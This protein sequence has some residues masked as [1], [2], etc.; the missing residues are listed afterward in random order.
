MGGEAG[1]G[2]VLTG[3]PPPGAVFLAVHGLRGPADQA[4]VEAAIRRRDPAARVWTH[5]PR[6]MVA[7][8]S[9]VAAEELRLAVQD[10]GFLARQ[11]AAEAAL[12]DPRSAGAAIARAIG[13]GFAGFVLGGLGGGVAGLLNLALNPVCHSGGD[14]GGCAMGIPA[15]TIGAALLGGPIGIALALARPRGR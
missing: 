10:A 1:Q 3:A 5:G 14:A 15:M 8:E 7:V 4:A 9:S 2:A 11:V 6:G 13:F 12:A